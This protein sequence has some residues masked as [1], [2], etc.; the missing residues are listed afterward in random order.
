M[1]PFE[2]TITSEDEGVIVYTIPMDPIPTSA[3]GIPYT[4]PVRINSTTQLR[5]AVVRAGSASK[6]QTSSYLRL[7]GGLETYTSPIPIAIIDNFGGGTIPNRGWSFATQTSAGL[8]QLPRQPACLHL[9][10]TDPESGRASITGVQD[11]TERIG[12]RVRGSFSSTWNPKPYSLET[13]D[14][15][16]N[17]KTATPLGTPRGVRLDSILPASPL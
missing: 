8:Q 9:I 16:D 14:E 10:D 4:G 13:W 7:S 12:I 5:A 3:N 2:V 15:Y 1:D 11:L 17:D 6:P